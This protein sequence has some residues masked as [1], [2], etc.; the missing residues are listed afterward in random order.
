MFREGFCS[1][2]WSMRHICAMACAVYLACL[3]GCA[4]PKV[5]AGP[6]YFPPAPNTPRM[7][8]LKGFSS[9]KDIDAEAT[10]FS[11]FQLGDVD[12]KQEIVLI[13][14]FGLAVHAGILYLSDANGRIIV[15]NLAKKEYAYLK[16][17]FGA[18]KLKKPNGLAFD[19]DGSLYVADTQRK[20]V[21]VYDKDG[22]FQRA[23]GKDLDLK[24]VDVAVDN[25]FLYVLDIGKNAVE[26]LGKKSGQLER[27]VG[28]TG[29]KDE[30][31][32]LPISLTVDSDGYLYVT[33]ALSGKVMKLDRDGHVLLSFGELGDAFGQFGRPRGIT[34]DKEGIIYV[35]DAS[36][37]NV[38]M[39][40]G[41]GRL[42]MFFGDPGL[43]D[44]SL[45][46]PAHV[47]VSYDNLEYFQKLADPSFVV[48]KVVFVTN[49]FGP[50][51]LSIYGFGHPRGVEAESHESGPP[52][53]KE[54]K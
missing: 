11:L 3:T 30:K 9:T 48:E 31:L 37:Q 46:L 22:N 14:P 44:G 23:L 49:Q 54:K 43:P 15:L 51:K 52:E 28:N 10:K 16:G 42:L 41:K 27:E 38:Q 34:V 32:A 45:N 18:G 39:F 6:V 26:I 1:S 40:N 21:L 4:G 25:D 19:A 17:D 20:E 13:K 24:P 8:Y 12:T 5:T 33:N 36:H 50:A 29:G 7:Q 2:V 53:K 35:A 47:A